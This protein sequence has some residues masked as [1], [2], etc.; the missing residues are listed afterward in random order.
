MVYGVVAW[1]R[2]TIGG[3]NKVTKV[4]NKVIKIIFGS[5]NAQTYVDNGILQFERA[6]EYFSLIKLHKELYSSDGS[7]FSDIIRDMQS[8][9]SYPTRFRNDL[10]LYPPRFSTARSSKCFIKQSIDLW[11]TLPGSLKIIHN[12]HKFKFELKKHLLDASH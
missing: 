6:F 10:N 8:D 3:T 1:G 9:H 7:Y 4:Q 2:R 11:N 12:A 5:H